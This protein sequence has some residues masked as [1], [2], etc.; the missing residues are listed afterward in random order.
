MAEP[1]DVTTDLRH[2]TVSASAVIPGSASAVFDYLR[3]PANHDAI[4]G[5]ETVRGVR[6]G[7]DVLGDGDSFGMKMKLFGVPYSVKSKVVEFRQDER[8]A[9][10]HAGGHRWRWEIEPVDDTHCRV[11]ETF[12]LTTSKLPAGL[13]LVGYPERHLDNVRQ[14]VVNV[15]AQFAA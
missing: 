5:D 10:C 1:S 14:S 12:D 9:W 13:R 15:A 11:T 2:D 8:I 7:P 6:T 4:S 3:R